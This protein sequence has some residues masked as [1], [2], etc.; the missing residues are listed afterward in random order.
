[1]TSHSTLPSSSVFSVDLLKNAKHHIFFL[2]QL[3][4]LFIKRPS[5]KSLQRYRDYWLP[6][7]HHNDGRLQLIPPPD[8][9]WL[10]HCHRLAPFRYTSYVKATF[11]SNINDTM[12][13]DPPFC[14]QQLDDEKIKVCIAGEMKDDV[15][16]LI[17][18][19][20]THKLWNELYPN[21]S[22][23]NN[24]EEVVDI[25]D[26]QEDI[27]SLLLGGFDLLCST[28]RQATFLW[29][30]SGPKF[31]SDDFL[32]DGIVN[33]YKFLK[34]QRASKKKKGM[35]LVPTYQI[36]LMW[37]THILTSITNYNADCKTIIG[38]TMNHD[39][40]FN[41]RTE[42]GPLDRAFQ[43]TKALWNAMYDGEEYTVPGGMYRGE[44]P[45]EYYSP[46]WTAMSCSNG[47]MMCPSGQFLHLIGI[48]GASSTNPTLVQGKIVEDSDSYDPS[49]IWCWK[50]TPSR[51]KQ[52]DS[53]TTQELESIFT[54]GGA[55]VL[56]L[57]NG[58]S[59]N[60]KT[61]K[62]IN[63]ATGYERDVKRYTETTK[64]THCWTPVNGKTPCGLL[65]FYSANPKATTRGENANPPKDDYIFGKAASQLGYYH[66]TTKEAYDILSSRVESK[67]SKKGIDYAVVSCL[68]CGIGGKGLQ[69][70]LQ[71]LKDI[72]GIVK[73]RASAPLPQGIVGLRPEVQQ[74]KLKRN[75]HYSDTGVWYFPD[76][77]CA[78]GG[79]CGGGFACGKH[80]TKFSIFYYCLSYI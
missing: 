30:V 41:D 7:L 38:T 5:Y 67:I 15:D 63:T 33:Y 78:A 9:A 18:A 65:A 52:Y 71:K 24:D 60:F 25:D 58:Y 12:E 44:P 22:F 54:A 42:D 48:Q 14:F 31:A 53:S 8:I 55:D 26:E 19:V 72:H 35:I 17:M 47:P 37:H 77:Y 2:Q 79:G 49:A 20:K 69:K 27:K 3:Q 36:D 51:I 40:S 13:A 32:E 68:T 45:R 56:D 59:V 80:V 10:W 21:E 70:E 50:E 74:D 76:C 29:Q 16:T 62:Q 66:I 39:D 43:E 61:M 75:R 46:S 23:S 64:E 57:G 73:A 6:L 34:L 4:P 1:M 11:G 28:D